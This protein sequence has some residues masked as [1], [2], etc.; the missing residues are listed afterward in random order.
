MSPLHKQADLWGGVFGINQAHRRPEDYVG[1]VG[2]AQKKKV[3]PV[4]SAAFLDLYTGTMLMFLKKS[5][6]LM[7]QR[8]KKLYVIHQH[9]Y[10]VTTWFPSFPSIMKTF[11]ANR[12]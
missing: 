6:M 11:P 12:N 4:G 9:K 10:N 3:G 2:F 5:T 1:P 8:G 7:H